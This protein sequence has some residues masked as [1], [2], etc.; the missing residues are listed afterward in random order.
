MIILKIT[1]K[2]QHEKCEKIGRYYIYSNGHFK[3]EINNK[4][5]TMLK[6]KDSLIGSL[7]KENNLI[8]II[9]NIENGLPLYYFVR[10]NEIIISSHIKSFLMNKI[11]LK[12][13]KKVVAE[14]LNYGYILPPNTIYKNIF[15]IPLL[16][17]IVIRLEDKM[18][19]IPERLFENQNTQGDP[20][21]LSSFIEENINF[22]KN[23]IYTLLFS[24]GLDS[25][26][27]CQLMK[28]QKVKFNMFSTGFDFDEK[29]LIEKKYSIS[30]SKELN[31]KTNYVSFDFRKLILMIP[32]IIFS[33]EEPISHIQT[34]LLYSLMKE[35]KDKMNPIIVNGQGA[36]GI[37]GTAHQFN[38]LNKNGELD[39]P[40]IKFA[41]LNFLKKDYLINKEENKRKF[42]EKLN[43]YKKIDRDFIIDLEGDVDNTIN[44]WTK[45]VNNNSFSI[46]YPFFQ[47]KFIQ[48]VSKVNW[49]SRLTEPKFILRWLARKNN[50][51][52]NLIIRKK[53]SFGPISDKWGE[54]LHS[55]LPISYDYFDKCKLYKFAIDKENR[56]ILWNVINYSIWKKI[57]IEKQPH[58]KIKIQLSKLMED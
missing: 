54:L 55:I 56:Y 16:S 8:E 17:K 43:G 25:S 44:S 13:N 32:E 46:I 39:L 5:K 20:V 41:K 33:T 57:F 23:K 45:C 29:D 6:F 22:D 37:F 58:N 15:R 1:T 31:K 2:K 27:L 7:D 35:Q 30:A 38:F 36:D 52:E 53:G 19:I 50:L 28:K 34:L 9:R 51:S 3:K 11:N 48:E 21:N 12:E 49:K 18:D 24:G 4:T 42:L 47:K 14:L 26:I 40:K 10:P